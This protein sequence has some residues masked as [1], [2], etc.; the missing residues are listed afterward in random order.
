MTVQSQSRTA[1]RQSTKSPIRLATQRK[2]ASVVRAG[3]KPIVTR[4]ARTVGA[5]IAT[6]TVRNTG[7]KREMTVRAARA[8]DAFEIALQNKLA[9]SIDKLSIVD[10][11]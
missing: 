4:R 6:W 3:R 10:A 2:T 7:T 9:K 8:S 11:E 1:R 5:F